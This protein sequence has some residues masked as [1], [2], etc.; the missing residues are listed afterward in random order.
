[1]PTSKEIVDTYDLDRFIEAQKEVYADVL[2]ELQ[3]GRKR[4]HWMWFMFPQA[5]GL[6]RSATAEFYAIQNLDEAE[7]YLNHPLLGTRLLECSNIVLG[8]QGR[9]VEDIFDWPDDL[10]LRSSMTLFSRVAGS[11]SVFDKV[12]QRYF[13]GELDKRTLQLLGEL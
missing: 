12:L 6:G 13:Q 5:A 1:M 4:T 11:G 7:T 3:S 2:A 8:L 10:K 9:S